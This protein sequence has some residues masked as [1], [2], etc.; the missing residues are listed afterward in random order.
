MIFVRKITRRPHGG[1]VLSTEVNID[2]DAIDICVLNIG[3]FNIE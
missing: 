3:V 1:R 2:I